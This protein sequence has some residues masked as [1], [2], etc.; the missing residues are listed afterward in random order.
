MNQSLTGILL[1]LIVDALNQV[2]G[3][4]RK[5]KT[6]DKL[7]GLFSGLLRVTKADYNAA[8]ITHTGVDATVNAIGTYANRFLQTA[9]REQIFL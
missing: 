5:S 1:E 8:A 3:F 6:L 2:S 9:W 7:V 4:T